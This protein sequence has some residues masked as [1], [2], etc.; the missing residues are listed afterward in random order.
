LAAA[1][2]LRGPLAGNPK[3]Q[4][5]NGLLLGILAWLGI[6]DLIFLALSARK[7]ANLAMTTALALIAILSLS[8]LRRSTLRAAG[9]VYIVGC[10]LI[11]SAVIT[12]SGG[13]RSPVLVYYSALPISAAWL[14]GR[15]GTLLTAAACIASAVVLALMETAGF[16]PYWYFPGV[17]F[18]LLSA[19]ILALLIAALPIAHVMQTLEHSLDQSG[20]AQEAL[21]KERDVLNRVMETSPAGIVAFDRDGR[22]NFANTRGALVLGTTS[23]EIYQRSYDSAEWNITA[24]DGQPLTPEQRPFF[25]V[26]S[27]GEALFGLQFATQKGDKPI[28]LSVNAAPLVDAAG[29][30]EGVVATIEDV[31]ERERVKREL[32]RHREDLEELVDQR[33]T[34]LVAALDQARVAD[35]ARMLFLANMSHELCTPLNAILGFSD[36]LRREAGMSAR[37]IEAL[38]I[39]NRSG[40]QLLAWV[41]DLLDVAKVGTGHGKLEIT[42]LDL[43]ELVHEVMRV[44][45][46]VAAEKKLG[47]SLVRPGTRFPLI[48]ADAPKLRQILTNLINNAIKYTDAGSI[49]LR[50]DIAPA[51]GNPK[52]CLRIEVQ[53][54]GIG[55]PPDDQARIFEPFVQLGQPN[56]RKGSGLGLAICHQFLQ[57]MGGA[58]QVES[59]PGTGS[60]FRVELLVDEAKE[61]ATLT[62]A[63]NVK[64]D[65]LAAD[66]PQFRVL[67]LGDDEANCLFLKRLLIGFQV[68]T[69]EDAESGVRVFSDWQPHIIFLDTQLQRNNR[70][71]VV[72][73]IRELRGGTEVK[74]VALMD[75]GCDAVQTAG[76]DDWVRKP[77]RPETVFGCMERLLGVRDLRLTPLVTRH[78]LEGVAALP[79]S[80]KSQLL[81]AIVLL[82]KERIGEVIRSISAVNPGLAGELVRRA[83]ALEFTAILRAVRSQ[84]PA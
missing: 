15:R 62:A 82:D 81:E 83:E 52:L 22:I 34:E 33:T 21:H 44:M 54:T 74:I 53:D 59:V 13:I 46:A 58:I 73:R 17:P 47:L 26:K 19:L 27:R 79:G 12:L 75:A 37:Q 7:P 71:D 38:E 23:D 68:Q 45:R 24:W 41:D 25:I 65:G 48:R 36:L 35:R 57:M 43:T 72:A 29:E 76:I 69:A 63:D 84:E 51:A 40:S 10:W 77:V 5:M 28:L 6:H 9:V 39:I 60:T 61:A 2:R 56:S 8:L 18:G 42:T 55:I 49:V 3:A 31:T 32:L 11:F 50:V 14:F 1:L 78:P 4:T 30:F 80:L 66:Q 16:G 20:L 67:L 64:L 70:L